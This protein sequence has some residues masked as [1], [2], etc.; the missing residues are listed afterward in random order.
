MPVVRT[1]P[2]RVS[3]PLAVELVMGQS[4]LDSISLIMIVIHH[5]LYAHSVAWHDL[6]DVTA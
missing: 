3:H 1:G 4:R 2:E 6:W 5:H